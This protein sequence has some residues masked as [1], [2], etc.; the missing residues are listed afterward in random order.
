MA[1]NPT[2][3]LSPMTR[4]G[5]PASTTMRSIAT[6]PFVSFCYHC[7]PTSRCCSK[8]VPSTEAWRPVVQTADGSARRMC[9]D[10]PLVVYLSRICPGLPFVHIFSYLFYLDHS[11]HFTFGFDSTGR[12]TKGD[13]LLLA[14]QSPCL[15]VGF[16]RRTSQDC[17]RRCFEFAEFVI[18]S[19]EVLVVLN[20]AAATLSSGFL[21]C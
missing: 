15:Q 5:G 21:W 8:A 14:L 2:E 16:F 6:Y 10:T 20:A 4:I 12:Q 18:M 17:E 3:I 1:P 11:S 9:R 7:P 13:L 19:A